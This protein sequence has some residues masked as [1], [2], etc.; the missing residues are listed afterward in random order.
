MKYYPHPS[1]PPLDEHIFAHFQSISYMRYLIFDMVCDPNKTDSFQKH[2][3][4]YAAENRNCEF[5]EIL[6]KCV[7][8]SNVNLADRY[9]FTAMYYAALKGYLS[10]QNLYDFL[11]ELS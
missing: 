4:I 6:T 2:G 5:V 1:S 8:V 9:G 3:L 7:P 11:D 10:F